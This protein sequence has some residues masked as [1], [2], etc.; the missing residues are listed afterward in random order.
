MQKGEIVLLEL[1][2]RELESGKV[3]E[4]SNA[5]VA[6]KEGVFSET[7]RYAPNPVVVGKGRMIQGVEEELL[8][9]NVGE[10]KKIILEP[11][12]AF[13]DRKPELVGIV[14]LKEFTA[15]KL[16]PF[17]G[18]IVDVNGNAGRVQS[19]SGGRVR[20]D[21]NSDLAGKTVEYE[22]KIVKKLE[23]P[24]EKAKAI[25]GKLLGLKLEELEAEFKAEGGE[26]EIELPESIEKMK[27]IILMKQF[28]KKELAEDIPEAKK[29]SF[30]GTPV[31]EGPAGPDHSAEQEGHSHEG[32]DHSHEGYEHAHKH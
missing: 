29:I 16:Q 32:H 12:M 11:S 4:T 6:K 28:L 21:F 30:K 10:E 24:V 20:V 9:M 19:V 1:T 23:T 17:P 27:E 15:R 3:F 5:E 25:M 14:P 8:K 2:G 26:L 7:A 22:L 31:I 18:L 13:G